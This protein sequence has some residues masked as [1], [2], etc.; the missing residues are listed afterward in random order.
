MW[1]HFYSTALTPLC[2]NFYSNLMRKLHYVRQSNNGIM[3]LHDKS[4]LDDAHY[5]LLAPVM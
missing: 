3:K 5:G 4:I 1:K 2:H